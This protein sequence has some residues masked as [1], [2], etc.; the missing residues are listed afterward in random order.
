MAFALDWVCF[1]LCFIFF[2]PRSESH[3]V[4]DPTFLDQLEAQLTRS[5]PAGKSLELPQS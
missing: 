1:V 3:Q 4:S 2:V 5:T